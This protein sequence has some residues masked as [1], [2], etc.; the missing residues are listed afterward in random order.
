MSTTIRRRLRTFVRRPPP[1]TPEISLVPTKLNRSYHIITCFEVAEHL[2]TH[3]HLLYLIHQLSNFD[4]I[5]IFSAAH[6][7]QPGRG[8]INCHWHGY[9]Y[10]LL[11]A[12]HI[13]RYNHQLT[14]RFLHRIG[15]ANARRVRVPHCYLNTMIFQRA[16]D[17]QA[18]DGMAHRR[19]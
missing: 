19:P 14:A 3:D 9:W 7:G 6:P 11:T 2:A 18:D 17:R 8:H 4:S 16:W 15:Q 10:D 13:W 12:N 5:L 1:Y